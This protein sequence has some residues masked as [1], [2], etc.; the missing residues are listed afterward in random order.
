VEGNN[1]LRLADVATV[2]ED[3]Q[4]LIG[5]AVAQSAPSLF[6]VIDKFPGANTRE[7]T[8]GVEKA[9]ADM[10]PGLQGITVDPNIHRPATYIEAAL[11][12][13]GFAGLTGLALLLAVMF[14]VFASWRAALIA[15]VVVPVSLTLR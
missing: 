4:P 14:L 15:F 12:N 7:V 5:D 11:K 6:L 1:A 8:S 13:V 3:H 9:L 10:A 2:I